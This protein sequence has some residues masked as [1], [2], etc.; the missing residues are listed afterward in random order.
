MTFMFLIGKKT[1]FKTS[2]YYLDIFIIIYGGEFRNKNNK[3]KTKN[4][5]T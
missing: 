1:S 5:K 4:S 2:G 3:Y